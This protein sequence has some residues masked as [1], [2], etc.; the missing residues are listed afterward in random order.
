M[1][2]NV[3]H[4]L[5]GVLIGVALCV[6]IDLVRRDHKTPVYPQKT[7]M[8][9]SSTTLD[10]SPKQE[11]SAPDL[12]VDHSYVAVVNGEKLE[13]PLK[14]TDKTTSKVTTVVDMTPIVSK[15]TPKWEAGIG[16]SYYNKKILPTISVQRNY[17]HDKAI[18]MSLYLKDN[19]VKGGSLM[20]KWLF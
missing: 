20:H 11:P 10:V 6:T 13:V 1:M 15:L 17:Q 3:K 14:T 16:V 8:V 9:T 12:V 2:N 7:P 18:E 5:L 4:L 19:Q